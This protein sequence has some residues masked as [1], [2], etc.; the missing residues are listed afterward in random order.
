M[1]LNKKKKEQEKKTPLLD[2]K[3]N[4]LCPI[5]KNYYLLVPE[6]H[7]GYTGLCGHP[8]CIAKQVSALAE[9]SKVW[10]NKIRLFHHLQIWED[11][12]SFLCEELL[13]EAEQGKPTIINPMWFRFKIL[14]FAH[15][16]LKKGYA[17]LSKVPA[18]YR[19]EHQQV[20]FLDDYEQDVIDNEYEKFQEKGEFYTPE[21]LTF[22]KEVN[23]FVEEKYGKEWVLFL[24]GEISRMDLS[25]LYRVALPKLRRQEKMIYRTLVAEFCDND[26]RDELWETLG[27]DGET[28][29]KKIIVH[30]RQD[31]L[32]VHKGATKNVERPYWET[33][34]DKINK[35]KGYTQ[36]DRT[37]FKKIAEMEIELAK[38]KEQIRGN[39]DVECE[40]TTT[41][42]T[43]EP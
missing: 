20:R 16:D 38:L 9:R 15:R 37:R 11:F 39:P 42:T 12:I 24:N 17:V 13:T 31:Y 26:T 41:E 30:S 23:E 34:S 35:S 2:K 19:A 18:Y 6:T 28:P 10:K 14:K 27:L 21:S 40:E 7:K 36:K 1:P 3:G 22:R 5:H 4:K 25:K 33:L 8:D 32:H 43:E 29:L